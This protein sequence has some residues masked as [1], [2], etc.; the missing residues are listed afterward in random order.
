MYQTKILFGWGWRKAMRGL[1]SVVI[2]DTGRAGYAHGP[3]P[4][5]G[6]EAGMQAIYGAV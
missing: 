2:H 5:P 1:P 3:L 6:G 4:S